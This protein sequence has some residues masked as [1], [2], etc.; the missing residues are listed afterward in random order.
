MASVRLR[1]CRVSAQADR[2][3]PGERHPTGEVRLL[4]KLMFSVPWSVTIVL[5]VMLGA[6]APEPTAQALSSPN[7]GAIVD[8][9]LASIMSMN[10]CVDAVLERVANP[11]QIL[12]V[13]HYSHN[14][15]AASASIEWARQFPANFDTAEEAIAAAPDIVLIGAHAAPQTV[16]ALR[17]AG[18]RVET[19]GVPAS[20]GESLEQ[21]GRI[22]VLTGRER[23]AGLLVDAVER[24]TAPRQQSNERPINAL[25]WLRGGL[26]PG[27]NTLVGEML[28]RAG[29]SNASRSY[30]LQDWDIMPGERLVAEPPE[31]IFTPEA[32]STDRSTKAA[33]IDRLEDTTKLAHL[34]QNLVYCAG[35]NLIELSERLAAAR[36]AYPAGTV[37]RK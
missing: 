13:S 8:R 19:F 10:P 18:I 25:V 26:V 33:I 6:C 22:G 12:S 23:Q 17:R 9:Q 28:E 15:S 36:A 3:I 20:V 5:T 30:G 27:S 32:E 7:S 16:A 14:P 29:F 21:I 35:P 24:A 31:V 37:A 2:G 1:S 4:G 11:N 34:P